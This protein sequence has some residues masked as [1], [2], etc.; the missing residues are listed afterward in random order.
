VKQLKKKIHE[1]RESDKE[2]HELVKARQE[3]ERSASIQLEIV[4]TELHD[5]RQEATRLRS[6]L[7]MLRGRK[8]GGAPVS[9]PSHPAVPEAHPEKEKEKQQ[10]VIRELSPQE[11]EKM[12]RLEHQSA[13][14]RARASEL[15][16]DVKR[17][18]SKADTQHRVYTATKGEAD[19]LRDKF[20]ALEKRLNRTLLEKDL[21]KRALKDLEKK[22]G[23]AAERTELTADE[24]AASDRTVDERIA[25]EAAEAARAQEKLAAEPAKSV[26]EAEAPPAPAP[27]AE[28]APAAPD[29]DRPAPSA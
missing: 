20:K 18:K 27:A 13:K 16:R 7:E 8:G 21:M 14:D 24:I 23:H 12:E 2:G 9:S 3:V 6:E 15:E 25:A 28:A 11:K 4:R 19:L 26:E 17:L 22:S 1:Q 5:A 10:R 29:P